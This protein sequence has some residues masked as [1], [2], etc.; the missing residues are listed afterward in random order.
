MSVVIKM[1]FHIQKAQQKWKSDKVNNFKDLVC[2][3]KTFSSCFKILTYWK[4]IICVRYWVYYR[5]INNAC[6]CETKKIKL[7]WFFDKF[8]S[9]KDLKLISKINFTQKNKSLLCICNL[10]DDIWYL[11]T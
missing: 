1:K 11:A 8:T 9:I 4:I 10:L 7:K 3:D 5:G 2:I 6:S